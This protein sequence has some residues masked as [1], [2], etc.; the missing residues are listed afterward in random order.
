MRS[1][2]PF[3]RAITIQVYILRDGEP[4]VTLLR[5]K[6]RRTT[7]DSMSNDDAMFDSCFT[8]F[9]LD[10]AGT[11]SLG[12]GDAAASRDVSVGGH[13]WRID[14]YPRGYRAEDNGEYVS[15]CLELTGD[16]TGGSVE[17]IFE[18]FVTKP[19]GA[20]SSSRAHRARQVYSSS[21]PAAAEGSGRWRSGSS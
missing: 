7:A 15:L 17:A 21:P 12:I 13:R 2:A 11:K 20:P 14:C 8:R 9:K 19:D 6:Y 3:I 5:S 16:S 10:Y 18:A 4:I 1:S